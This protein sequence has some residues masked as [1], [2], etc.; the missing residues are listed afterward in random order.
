[1]QATT[2]PIAHIQRAIGRHLSHARKALLDEKL[3]DDSV[4]NARKSLKRARSGLRLLR[5]LDEKNY[6][7]GNMRLRNVGRR[8]SGVRDHRVLLARIAELLADED[9]PARRKLLLALRKDLYNTRRRDWRAL[10]SHDALER[11]AETLGEVA[12]DVRRWRLPPESNGATELAVE[13]LYRKGRKALARSR[14]KPTNE[15]LHEARKQAKHLAHA[16]EMLGNGATP[17]KTKKVLSRAEDLGDWLGDDH[18]L[19]V[20]ESRFIAL[21]QADEKPKRKLRATLEKRRGR[22]QR[23][24]LKTADKLFR[25]KTRKM[26]ARAAERA[27][28]SAPAD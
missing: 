15:R 8:L 12:R 25:K 26:L 1:M 14:K 23:K 27:S 11:I 2:S 20:V 28:V 18:D 3:D 24:A 16:L 6:Q 22:L 9:K 13:I 5:P 21:P 7:R 17:K 10:R 4:H 19:A